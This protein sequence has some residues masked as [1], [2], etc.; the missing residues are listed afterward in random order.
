MWALGVV[1]YTLLVG[2]PPFQAERR[3]RDAAGD[4]VAGSPAALDGGPE[5]TY[6]RILQVRP[7]L[8]PPYV[9]FHPRACLLACSRFAGGPVICPPG[10]VAG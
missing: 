8:R 10:N 5:S 1:L 2:R 4:P 9:M 3:G 6:A 7:P